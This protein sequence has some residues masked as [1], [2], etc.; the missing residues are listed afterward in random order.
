MWQSLISL[1]VGYRHI[2]AEKKRRRIW[3]RL[4]ILDTYVCMFFQADDDDDDDDN[5]IKIWFSR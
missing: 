5:D 1:A 4:Y 2:V 3:E